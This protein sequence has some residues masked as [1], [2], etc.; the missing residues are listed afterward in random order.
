[1]TDAN[2]MVAVF[3]EI[4]AGA[5]VA[6]G[7]GSL[8]LGLNACGNMVIEIGPPPGADPSTDADT[9]VRQANLADIHK[10]V[11]G[12]FPNIVRRNA[13]LVGQAPETEVVVNGKVIRIPT[14][15]DHPPDAAN[16]AGAAAQVTAPQG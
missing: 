13:D 9:F 15:T 4:P 8:R 5:Q 3:L 2:R 11:A 6:A 1:M 7:G 12:T 14:G 16:T 10:A